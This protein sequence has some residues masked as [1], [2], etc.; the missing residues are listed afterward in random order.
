MT[1]KRI[2]VYT[3]ATPGF[4]IANYLNNGKRHINNVPYDYAYRRIELEGERLHI[5]AQRSD[6]S[7]L[8]ERSIEGGG[9]FS[10]ADIGIED[11]ANMLMGSQIT[12]EYC[13]SFG[14]FY[15]T[16]SLLDIVSKDL[17][18]GH[19]I[20]AIITPNYSNWMSSLF[21]RY[22]SRLN[23]IKLENLILPGVHDAGMYIDSALLQISLFAKTQLD[24]TTKQLKMGARIFDIRPGYTP[25]NDIRHLHG[26]DVAQGEYYQ[27]MLEQITQ[28]LAEN[29]Q[30]IVVI[31]LC[32]DGIPDKS[33]TIPKPGV[34]EKLANEAA[35][36]HGIKIGNKSSLRKSIQKLID[37]QE[38]L[39]IVSKDYAIHGGEKLDVLSSYGS[40][41]ES[42]N[43][44]TIVEG[45]KDV[46]SK[47]KQEW[48][49]ADLI[50]ISL[51]LTAS[52]VTK[53][54]TIA[55]SLGS[56]AMFDMSPLVATKAACDATSYPWIMKNELRPDSLNTLVGLY[57]DFYD[58]GQTAVTIKML[59]KRLDRVIAQ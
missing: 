31:H 56:D 36:N 17:P 58:G 26:S 24:N 48:D 25:L 21:S 8:F 12:D 54:S 11:R 35:K 1:S 34:L 13:F 37:E 59:E 55:K 46:N 10:R 16:S 52:A 14:L 7:C 49:D 20:R 33:V 39:I 18:N 44:N 28:F 51:Q 45:L 42:L 29:N 3:F 38:R 43:T 9:Y 2:D 19:Q 47:H 53:S 27:S 57:N 6:G 22:T 32:D 50:E 15:S 30:E 40:S 23:E 5:E 41:Y 4:Q